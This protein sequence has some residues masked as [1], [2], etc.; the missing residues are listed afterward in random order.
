VQHIGKNIT[1]ALKCGK[2]ALK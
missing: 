2:S 1:A